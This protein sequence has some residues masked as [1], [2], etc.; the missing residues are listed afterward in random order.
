MVKLSPKMEWHIAEK[1]CE[2]V[3][4]D[5]WEAI[6]GRA[7]VDFRLIT[8]GGSDFEL[9]RNIVQDTNR[10]GKLPQYLKAVIAH[11][12]NDAGLGNI[13]TELETGY[14]GRIDKLVKAIKSRQC[15]LFLGPG[16]LI[17]NDTGKK[18][19]NQMLGAHLA[20]LLEEKSKY[21]D[22]S[23]VENL[24]YMVQRYNKAMDAGIG[25]TGGEARKLFEGYQAN[26][27]LYENVFEQLA[28]LPWSLIINTNADTTLGE[29]L[30]SNEKDKCLIRKYNLTGNFDNA[31][32]QGAPEDDQS[33]FYNLFGR[34]D[35]PA[36]ILYTD[37]DFVRFNDKVTKQQPRLNE[38]VNAMFDPLKEYLFLGFDFDQWYFKILFK[39]LR[40]EKEKAVSWHPGTI[41]F[42]ECNIDFFEE[43]YKFY[44]VND[45]VETFLKNLVSSYKKLQ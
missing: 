26:G 20:G 25:E 37:A 44:F 5:T 22:K 13:I 12:N 9:C 11:F 17:V 33:L 8:R 4:G 32:N 45:N 10:M 39:A 15:I 31:N 34:F 21:Y 19:F 18:P 35:D 3:D 41:K 16:A 29:L 23:Q 30:N 2:Q 36:S 28:A 27:L 38:Y 7:G 1:L 6:A 24:N 43:E 14:A 42:N 40:L